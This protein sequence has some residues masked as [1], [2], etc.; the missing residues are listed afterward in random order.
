MKTSVKIRLMLS[1][2]RR[3][4]SLSGGYELARRRRTGTIN[5][6]FVN[7][8]RMG[9]S[10]NIPAG[11]ARRK[12]YR[13]AKD[14][15]LP[16]SFTAWDTPEALA[17]GSYIDRDSVAVIERRGRECVFRTEGDGKTHYFL[18]GFDRNEW[19]RPLY[20]LAELPR[21]VT[22]IKEAREALKPPSVLQAE[23][24]GKRVYRQGDMFAI[25]TK[26]TDEEILKQGGIIEDR[27]VRGFG[28]SRGVRARSLYGTAHTAARVASM[29][30]GIQFA[31][32]YL[33]HEPGLIGRSGRDHQPCPL[34]PRRWHLVARNTVPVAKPERWLDGAQL[35][36]PAQ[37]HLRKGGRH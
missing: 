2:D 17:P 24:M 37:L 6:I 20:F 7:L 14:P 26:I 12:V 5:T 23:K 36:N 4:V 33:Y 16:V 32:G 28:S 1:G 34:H 15:I 30:N 3:A 9:Y 35:D 13:L 29:P 19:P 22:S 8:D 31:W 11:L 25:P 21:K 18:S 10:L 27:E